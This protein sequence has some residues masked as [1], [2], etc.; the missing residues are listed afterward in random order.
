MVG[1]EA[2]TLT[3]TPPI[4]EPTPLAEPLPDATERT[5][6]ACEGVTKGGDARYAAMKEVLESVG[7]GAKRPS[8][9]SHP[10]ER[11]WSGKRSTGTTDETTPMA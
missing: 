8:R 6:E 5:P 10:K 7:K 11:M 3:P 2:S 4:T 9:S 1:A